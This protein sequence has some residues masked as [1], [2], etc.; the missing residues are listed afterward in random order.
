MSF[1]ARTR[2]RIPD[3]VWEVVSYL[4]IGGGLAVLE[5]ALYQ[6]AY[7]WAGRG[8]V[9]SKAVATAVATVTAYAL[10]KY[11]SFG[12][13]EG[14]QTHQEFVLFVVVNVV[15]FVIGLAI[16]AFARYGLGQ[17][18]VVS[19]QVANVFSIAVGVVL[20][21]LAYRRWVFVR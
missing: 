9:E 8:A 13:R 12:H 18:G 6:A 1:A 16:M 5:I 14:R 11:V 15:T 10:H 17:T 4:V 19:L 7:A 3:H 21:F 2:A 20:R